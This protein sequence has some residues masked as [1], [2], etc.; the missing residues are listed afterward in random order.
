VGAVDVRPPSRDDFDAAFNQTVTILIAESAVR[1]VT[2]VG[3][4]AEVE[5]ISCPAQVDDRQTQLAIG[6]E[7]DRDALMNSESDISTLEETLQET[8]VGLFSQFCDPEVR[9]VPSS[10]C[11]PY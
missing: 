3:E 11:T 10:I 4:T 1:F 6:A 9:N 2:A 7:G 5:E 8:L